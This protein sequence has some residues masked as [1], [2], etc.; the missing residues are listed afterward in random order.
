MFFL[1]KT[2]YTTTEQLI[3]YNIIIEYICQLLTSLQCKQVTPK[4][5]RLVKKGSLVDNKVIE[6]ISSDDEKPNAT[7]ESNNEKKL[8]K[9][10]EM[11]V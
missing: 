5:R 6:I 7:S 4:R 11:A 8:F 10:N 9:E 1:Y 3:V 2:Y